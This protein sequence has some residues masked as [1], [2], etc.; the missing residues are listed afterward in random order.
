M[1]NTILFRKMLGKKIEVESTTG[2]TNG[3]GGIEM[4][5]RYADSREMRRPKSQGSEHDLPNF[6]GYL[7]V[8]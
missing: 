1:T 4:I 2:V 8:A 3:A 5:G 7:L 6:C